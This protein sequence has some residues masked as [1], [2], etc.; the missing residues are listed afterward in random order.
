MSEAVVDDI[1]AVLPPLLQS[2]E[3]LG[4]IARHLNPP[5]FGRGDGSRRHA[6]SGVAG[7]SVRGWPIGR[8]NSQMCGPRCKRRATR[9]SRRSTDCAR[10]SMAMATSS[11]CFARCV[12]PRARRRRCIRWPRNCR[13]SAASSSTLRCA[14]TP[15]LMARLA[16][17][18]QRK[19]RDRSRSQRTR[20]PRRLLALCA[21]ILHA[22][23]RLA[24][25]DGAAWRQR[26][27]PRLPVELAAR[28]AQPRRHPGRTYRDRRHSQKHLG[29]DGRR[30]RHAEP[31]PHS[32]YRAKP[33]ERRSRQ[34]A[35]DR[36]ERRRHVLLC[37]AGWRAPRPSPILRRSPP[38][39]IR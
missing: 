31:R 15:S 27:W 6:G 2:L 19:H 24:A 10:Y 18:A 17:P 32:R 9:R 29:V 1:V 13:R 3:A 14:K 33:L 26:Q 11:R 30:H 35:A 16:E 22:R 37:H 39:S 34:A 8:T 23:P 28:C 7:R 5:D 12:M 25:G 36:N 20:Q 4:F 21:G 38:P